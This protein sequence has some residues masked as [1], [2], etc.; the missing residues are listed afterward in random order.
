M[1]T[2]DVGV[3]AEA[4][5]LALEQLATAAHELASGIW[6]EKPEP[7]EIARRIRALGAAEQSVARGLTAWSQAHPALTEMVL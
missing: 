1:T 7:A 2:R 6:N 3:E 4:A 5:V